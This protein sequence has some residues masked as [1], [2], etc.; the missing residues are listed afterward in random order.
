MSTT[1]DVA[2]VKQ[3]E[4]EVHMAYQRM[5]SKL[6]GTVR[7]VN[8]VKGESTT[9]QKI[10]A[11]TAGQKSRHGMVPIMNLEHTK[12]ECTLLDRYAAEYIDKLDELKINHNERG[13]VVNS[14]SYALGRATDDDII[15]AALSATGTSTTLVTTSSKTFRNSFLVADQALNDRDVPD[16]GRRWAVVSPSMWAWLMTVA[17]FSSADYVGD[18][19]VYNATMKAAK[20]WMGYHWIRHTGLNKA[21]NDRTGFLWHESAIGHA[22]GADVMMDTAWIAEKA[23]WFFNGMMS[24]GA[25]LIDNNGVQEIVLDESAA[26]PTS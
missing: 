14:I 7:T 2:F 11:G 1:I 21:T 25:C 6:R 16:D 12:V 8:N 22:I 24:M 4:R 23:T 3:F 13:A 20:T 15:T 5:G 18:Q 10:G 26:L 9:F 17:E 19:L